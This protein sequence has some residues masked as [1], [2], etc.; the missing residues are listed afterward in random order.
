MGRARAPPA[1]TGTLAFVPTS[2]PGGARGT[3]MASSRAPPRSASPACEGMKMS[4]L[5]HTARRPWLV[6]RPEPG[7]AAVA[8]LPSGTSSH[9]TWRWTRS[10]G[11]MDT[12]EARTEERRGSQDPSAPRRGAANSGEAGSA[13]GPA[14]AHAPPRARG[15][16]PLGTATC[17]TRPCAPRPAGACPMRLCR[18]AAPT[19]SCPVGLRREAAV[20]S[21]GRGGDGAPGAWRC[22]AAARPSPF[23]PRLS[24]RRCVA[25][26][27]SSALGLRE[28]STCS[29]SA[30][31][32][33]SAMLY[34]AARTPR[35]DSCAASRSRAAPQP[36]AWCSRGL[37]SV[38]SSTRM[39]P[40][41]QRS[42]LW[43][44]GRPVAPPA[45][46]SGAM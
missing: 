31:S 44:Y 41:L 25:A 11:G 13:M 6:S 32:C 14:P 24:S 19:P 1:L 45:D 3:W 36:P 27:T 33:S 4:M 46:T 37:R 35:T 42:A 29:R 22:P 40:Q 20:G 39:T 43:P 15:P 38:A 9:A 16:P 7:Q 34:P 10:P 30:A 18:G 8:P 26:A 12:R 17:P 2:R 23:P 21:E 5:V 28:A